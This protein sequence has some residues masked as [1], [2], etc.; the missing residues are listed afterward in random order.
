MILQALVKRYEDLAQAGKLPQPGYSRV[1]VSFA[2]EI[3]AEGNL[4]HVIPL[5]QENNGKQVAKEM[6]APEQ[7]S[8]S[9][10]VKPHFLCDN[11]SYFLGI[12]NKGKPERTQ[13]C[14]AAASKLHQQ[15]LRDCHSKA[16]KA[17]CQFFAT[18][19]AATASE[20]PV[21]QDELENILQGG[22]ITFFFEKAFVV[23]DKEIQ[24]A[25]LKYYQKK[26]DDETAQC[27]VS[28]RVAP[29][30]RLHPKIKGVLGAQAAGANIVSF[31]AESANS[32]GHQQ[33]NNAPVSEYAA[34]AYGTALNDLL[35]DK[36]HRQFV[37]DMTI[38][39]WAE[40]ESD[41]CQDIFAGLCFDDN[42]VMSNEDLMKI[43]QNLQKGKS[44]D[45]NGLQIPF[46]NPFYILALAPNAAR[47]SVRFFLQGSFGDFLLNVRAHHERT[48][49]FQSK[50][51]NV[52][53]PPLWALLKAT[54][55]P[56]S[57]DKA[58]SPLL[59]GTTLQ[60]VLLNIRYPYALYEQ[61]L[62]RIYAEVDK[63]D[64][65][66]PQYKISGER[67]AIIKAVLLKNYRKEGV[68]QVA[69]NEQLNDTAYILG[70]IFAVRENI[71]EKANPNLNSTIKDRYFDAA[72]TK[73]AS[74]FALL[75][76]LTNHH[77][78][79]MDNAGLKVYFEKKLGEL[80]DRLR[81][82]KGI[83]KLLNPEEQGMFVLGYYQ[84]RQDLFTK[85]NQQ[86][87]EK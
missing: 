73:P 31:N 49:I 35:S 8:R 45:Y 4:L 5:Q 25:W 32:Y 13:Q 79:K 71:Q 6:M 67:A 17:I 48:A 38:V 61:T 11:S 29:V 75:E 16:A 10:K 83:P 15:I 62:L 30:A 14:F 7:E 40:E 69:L 28:G 63:T 52:V 57:K 42:R 22:N 64:T 65:K 47:I 26:A 55:N 36:A 27:L 21:L 43:M 51:G 77:L 70:R 66:P 33:G 81:A 9:V 18:W 41:S 20:N 82:E 1:K 59:A 46:D 56:A 44:V 19:D 23:K 80:V 2:L 58:G 60:S 78:Q 3:D 37:G 86:E 68:I 54:A 87:A 34:F 74:V 12:D 39:Y 84:Q 85:K 53:S 50:R 76:H 72:S 24:A